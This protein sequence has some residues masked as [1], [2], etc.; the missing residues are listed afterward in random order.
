MNV[1]NKNAVPTF[2]IEPSE[3]TIETACFGKVTIHDIG[4]DRV[5]A[6]LSS[7]SDEKDNM[8]LLRA[9]VCESAEGEHGERFTMEVLRKLPAR[10]I[11]DRQALMLAAGR[12]NGIARKDV[13]KK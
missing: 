8:P 5:E 10:A 13:E 9:L 4:A 12:V 7:H 6:L 3:E 11:Q 1:I 2:S